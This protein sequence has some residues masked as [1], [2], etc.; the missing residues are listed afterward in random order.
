MSTITVDTDRDEFRL[1]SGRR[2]YANCNVLGIGPDGSVHTGYD[3]HLETSDF[4]PE[5]R[6]ELA[7]Y[8]IA[9][10]KAWGGL[11]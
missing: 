7:E 11:P 2:L 1:W 6:R 3:D 8:A 4:T 5:E 9:K 10:W